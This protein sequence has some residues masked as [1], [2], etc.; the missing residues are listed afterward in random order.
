MKNIFRKAAALFLAATF[1]HVPTVAEEE[2]KALYIAPFVSSEQV[3]RTCKNLIDDFE[4]DINGWTAE[5]AELTLTDDGACGVGCLTVSYAESVSLSL[6]FESV[7]ALEARGVSAVFKSKGGGDVNI[8][9]S[10]SFGNDTREGTCVIPSGGWYTVG[11]DISGFDDERLDSVKITAE[12]GDFAVDYVHTSTVRA[13]V[14]A[15]E[16]LTDEYTFS[17]ASYD[18]DG[19]NIDL[20]FNKKGAQLESGRIER[21]LMPGENALCITLDNGAEISKMTVDCAESF[22]SY[23]SKNSHTFSVGGGI[24]TYVVPLDGME[25]LASFKISFETKSSG[26]V[27]IYNISLTSYEDTDKKGECHTD[28]ENITVSFDAKIPDSCPVYLY[29]G[30]FAE[31]GAGEVYKTELTEENTF[32]FPVC[33]GEKNNLLYKYSAAY[34]KDGELVYLCRNLT[35]DTPEECA[36]SSSLIQPL[37]KKGVFGEFYPDTGAVFLNIDP[38]AFI[39]DEETKYTYTVGGETLYVHTDSAEY[40]D[41][42]VTGISALDGA[43]YICIPAVP[44]LGELKNEEFVYKYSAAVGYIASRYNGGEH[45]TV[46]G[47]VIGDGFAFDADGADALDALRCTGGIVYY[48]AR[49]EN[50]ESRVI[51]SLDGTTGEE[52]YGFASSAFAVCPYFT[53]IM[54]FC[55]DDVQGCL[56]ADGFDMRKLVS[57]LEA[58]CAR[59]VGLFVYAEG[60]GEP[61][62][63]L[64][65]D[66]YSL[67]ENT[68]FECLVLDYAEAVKCGNVFKHMDTSQAGR[69]VKELCGEAGLSSWD[70]LCD[71]SLFA[72][73]VRENATGYISYGA[74]SGGDKIFTNTKGGKWLR[75]VGCISLSVDE[76]YILAPLDN[77]VGYGYAV[78]VPDEAVTVQNRTVSV[79]LKA[80]YLGS[81]EETAEVF[82]S[83]IGG[84]N[85]VSCAVDVRAG[86]DTVISFEC[87]GVRKAEKIVIGIAEVGTPRLCISECVVS[88]DASEETSEE[89]NSEEITEKNS[90]PAEKNGENT[91]FLLIAVLSILGAFFFIGLILLLLSKKTSKKR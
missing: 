56:D 84:K 58:R 6:S 4:N 49:S 74:L 52:L 22:G 25:A 41:R 12:G 35:A 88:R 36:E 82:I 2:S 42:R 39:S 78:F 47:F 83:V 50:A 27:R 87:D 24:G 69:Y 18:I 13:P 14:G 62:G 73:N 68:S 66:F 46:N 23:K 80:D 71:T 38:Y 67:Y 30:L 79:K 59:E 44:S 31:D 57:A 53:D 65:R 61:F 3:S 86:V 19:G 60:Y 21:L 34:E 5:G 76:K 85:S 77:S 72:E 64:V 26:A 32:V 48:S 10:A 9:F 51:L 55:A 81:G 75:G 90:D 11:L 29:R 63:T 20:T 91:V 15:C 1:L 28:G 70:E 40:L 89:K 45:G 7:S 33:D 43:V 54:V 16:N 37:L 8:T 17:G